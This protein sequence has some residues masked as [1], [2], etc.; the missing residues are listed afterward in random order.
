MKILAKAAATKEQLQG[1]VDV[2]ASG[3]EI[4]LLSELVDGKVGQYHFAD[5][6][7]DLD[8]IKQ[9][10]VYVVHAPILSYYGL[11]DV[12]LEDMANTQDF[13]L[14]DQI[15]YIA[16][17]I[18]EYHNRRTIIVVHSE[19]HREKMIGLGDTWKTLMNSVG[20]LLM[21]Y[22]YTEMAIENITPLRNAHSETLW[23]SNNFKFDNVVMAHEL[24]K[25]LRTDRVGTVLDLCHARIT[26]IYM[27]A[28]YDV[29]GD[30]CEDYSLDAY[31]KENA[32]VIKLIHAA[33]M[34]GDGFGKGKH[35]TPFEDT[36]ESIAELRKFIEL[37]R[38]YNYNCLVTLEVSETDFIK[39]YGYV[40]SNELLLRE[41]KRK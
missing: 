34:K 30:E 33:D 5:E 2:N 40:K 28:I 7:F 27:K 17:T 15:F 4:Q 35:G 32:D 10:D 14:L 41:L 19:M 21:K 8:M 36:P 39:S 12:N 22:P 38:K 29:L 37:Y 13:K 11:S 9:Y 25:Q 23:L 24:R 16:N 31:F 1:K 20:C 6:V 18:G 26:Q 3:I